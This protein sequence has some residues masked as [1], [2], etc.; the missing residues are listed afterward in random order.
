MATLP[1]YL[2]STLNVQANL[3]V[4]HLQYH[5]EIPETP[6]LVTAEH[7]QDGSTIRGYAH[8][9]VLTAPL[10]Q[11]LTLLETIHKN[12]FS[13]R[14]QQ[15]LEAHT[16]AMR[17]VSYHPCYA[18]M[19]TVPLQALAD[20]LKALLPWPGVMPYEQLQAHGGLETPLG[21]VAVSQAKQLGKTLVDTQGQAWVS[22]TIQSAPEWSWQNLE[23]SLDTVETA[24]LKSLA[25]VVLHDWF[26]A[27][28]LETPAPASSVLAHKALHRWRY[29]AVNP[30][31]LS[32][33]LHT[34]TQGKG[35]LQPL[36]GLWVAGDGL[37]GGRV[38]AALRSGYEVAQAIA[39][40]TSA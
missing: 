2:A 37:I 26:I 21:W 11:T 24:L 33:T 38:E 9:V 31:T 18:L 22:L 23:T 17:G 13:E 6:W 1:K 10:P 20:P 19:L 14:F 12:A 15:Q 5:P 7:T 39:S 27:K 3:L 30:H 4:K 29:S 36:P 34:L 8:D 32:D 35:Y 25:H 16:F 28:L 40:A